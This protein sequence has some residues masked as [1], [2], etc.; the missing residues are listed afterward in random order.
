MLRDN[1]L[2]YYCTCT[3]SSLLKH[4]NGIAYSQIKTNKQ[5]IIDNIGKDMT[6]KSY[7]R[8]K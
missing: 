8:N 5:Y 1:S 7:I 3:C 6:S 4:E 2:N